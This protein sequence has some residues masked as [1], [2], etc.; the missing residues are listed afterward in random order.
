[1][2]SHTMTGE[3][4]EPESAGGGV[5]MDQAKWLKSEPC[6]PGNR[7]PEIITIC[8]QSFLLCVLNTADTF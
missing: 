6:M 7:T 1:M 4:I 3:A 5:Y 8:V 2:A